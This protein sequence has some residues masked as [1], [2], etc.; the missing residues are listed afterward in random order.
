[1][2]NAEN[3]ASNP[4]TVTAKLGEAGNGFPNPGDFVAGDDLWVVMTVESCVHTINA[5]PDWVWADLVKADWADLVE[6]DD[7]FDCYVAV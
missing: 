6:D 3:N 1:M 7:L 4:E 2:N 5:G